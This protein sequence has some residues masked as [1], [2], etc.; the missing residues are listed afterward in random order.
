MARWGDIMLS[1]MEQSQWS[2]MPAI[3]IYMGGNVL[4]GIWR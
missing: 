3:F 1:P 2:V 4:P